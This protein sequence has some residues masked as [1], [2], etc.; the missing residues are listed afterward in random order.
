M[1]KGKEGSKR[2]SNNPNAK[3]DE[4]KVAL[5]KQDIVNDKSVTATAQRQGVARHTVYNIIN[6]L[7]WVHVPWPE[8]QPDEVTPRVCMVTGC[9]SDALPA[10]RFCGAHPPEV[11]RS[12]NEAIRE[13]RKTRSLAQT[14]AHFGLSEGRVSQICHGDRRRRSWASLHP[15][16]RAQD[17]AQRS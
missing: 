6:E 7:A 17:R 9:S 10:E 2:G 15:M 14:A 1:A 13:M 5:I 11:V 4:A 8:P 3:I 16:H 12:R